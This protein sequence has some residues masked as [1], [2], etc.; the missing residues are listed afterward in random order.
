MDI[1]IMLR[2]K[3]NATSRTEARFRP[4]IDDKRVEE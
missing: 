3:P 2:T 1:K 4:D